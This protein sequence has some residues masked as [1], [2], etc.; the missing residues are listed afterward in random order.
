M[1]ICGYQGIGKSSISK[2]GSGFIDLESGNFWINGERNTQWYI[3]YC[4]IAVHL[5]KQGH[6]VF[7]SSHPAVRGWLLNLKYT[8]TELALA[9]PA[10]ELKDAWI[11]RLRER[12]LKSMSEK[13]YKALKNAE[14]MYDEGITEMLHEDS[15]YHKFVIQDMNYD[16]A[17]FIRSSI[18]ELHKEV[19]TV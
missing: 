2:E 14:M 5:S 9:F 1:I 11:Q 4:N 17:D 8:G 16:L 15:R 7:V 12:Y 19:A 3:P 18:S 6:T 13:N 10:L